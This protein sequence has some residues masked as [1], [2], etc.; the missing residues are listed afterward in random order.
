[1]RVRVRTSE[2]GDVRCDLPWLPAERDGEILFES[3]GTLLP[4]GHVLRVELGRLPLGWMDYARS[5]A[6]LGLIGLVAGTSWLLVR[7]RMPGHPPL[8]RK[9]LREPPESR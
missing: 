3:D 6:V 1:M 7:R 2:P 8:S 4:A 9:E 5:A